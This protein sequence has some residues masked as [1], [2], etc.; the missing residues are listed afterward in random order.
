M[1]LRGPPRDPLEPLKRP[2]LGPGGSLRDGAGSQGVPG[3]PCSASDHSPPVC[4]FGDPRGPPGA[5]TC[6][7]PPSTLRPFR[8]PFKHPLGL[9][10]EPGT[11]GS[12]SPPRTRW[13]RR[14][15]P[16]TPTGGARA[17]KPGV[18]S[19]RDHQAPPGTTSGGPRRSLAGLRAPQ[20]GD[21]LQGPP[22]TPGAASRAT[23]QA[24]GTARDH[25]APTGTTRDIHQ[26]S[27]EHCHPAWHHS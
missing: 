11:V 13:C 14:G 1:E 2:Q 4:M 3:G 23:K 16:R 21:S 9:A 12:V 6:S 5:N 17:R 8:L 10:L 27:P 22:G 26:R 18:G 7:R 19:S 15:P 24:L 20:P 25:Q